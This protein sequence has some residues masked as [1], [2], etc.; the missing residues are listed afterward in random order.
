MSVA[1]LD[2]YAV[3]YAEANT[4]YRKGRG[5]PMAS[6]H[7]KRTGLRAALIVLLC[8]VFLGVRGGCGGTVQPG[9]PQDQGIPEWCQLALTTPSPPPRPSPPPLRRPAGQVRRH[10][11]SLTGQ[12]TLGSAAGAV[13][14]GHQHRQRCPSVG[15]TSARKDPFMTPGSCTNTG[16]ARLWPS[17]RWQA[18]CTAGLVAGQYISRPAG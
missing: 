7:K 4:F 1:A 5:F 11:R 12:Y 10:H 18:C 16:A 6:S 15:C 14:D 13:P 9:Q 17:I 2:I 8:L 3:R